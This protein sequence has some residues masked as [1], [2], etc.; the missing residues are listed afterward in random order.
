MPGPHEVIATKRS[1][2]HLRFTTP[3]TIRD[4]DTGVWAEFVERRE[5]KKIWRNSSH[6]HELNKI[7]KTHLL[8][9]KQQT[10]GPQLHSS[11]WES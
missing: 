2:V 5:K 4:V 9:A 7:N 1:N 6:H 8:L 3:W 10:Y 11:H